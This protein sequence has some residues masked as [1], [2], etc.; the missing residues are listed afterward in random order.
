MQLSHGSSHKP[1][2][3]PKAEPAHGEHHKQQLPRS[4]KKLQHPL[5]EVN[6]LQKPKNPGPTCFRSVAMGAQGCTSFLQPC[7][8]AAAFSVASTAAPQ[9]QN[10]P[11]GDAPAS[12]GQAKVMQPMPRSPLF[13]QVFIYSLPCILCLQIFL[14]AGGIPRKGCSAPVEGFYS[15]CFCLTLNCLFESQLKTNLVWGFLCLHK[16]TLQEP[17]RGSENSFSELL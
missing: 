16:G 1:L 13:P 5:T 11:R 15:A 10:P 6:E 17:G 12:Q 14:L 8:A 7:P 9:A 2:C 3:A 4:C